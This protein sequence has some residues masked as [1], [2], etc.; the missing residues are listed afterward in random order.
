MFYNK[1]TIFNTF[2]AS[3]TWLRLSFVRISIA[4]TIVT[5]VFIVVQIVFN[6]FSSS[7]QMVKPMTFEEPMEELIIE[8]NNQPIF[9]EELEYQV[10]YD[11]DLA[12]QYLTTIETS[13]MMLEYAIIS[14]EYSSLAVVAMMDE[15]DRLQ[16]IYNQIQQ[17]LDQSLAWESEFYYAAKTYTFL[18]QVGYNDAVICG[19][20]GNMMIE[21]SGGTLDLQPTVYSA[22]ENYYGLCQW[23]LRHYPQYKGASFEQQLGY[24]I[25]SV[26]YEFNT[27]G[28]L[29]KKSFTYE[30]FLE[31]TDPA[32]AAYAFAKVYE[33]CS[34]AGYKARQAAALKA[35]EYFVLD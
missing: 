27:F 12:R 16:V 35:Y 30:N 24:L 29:Y 1:K 22:S 8:G 7:P 32:E 17:D 33:R 9:F 6:S 11:S 5:L 23:D 13:F 25:E 31:I 3:L 26:P 34:S 10:T 19:I 20:I 15:Y 14:G 4:L 28:K 18:K 2:Y 21:T